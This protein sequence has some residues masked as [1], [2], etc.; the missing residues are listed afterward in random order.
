[1]QIGRPNY[2]FKGIPD[3][4]WL[5]GFSSGDGSFN[6]KISNSTTSVLG[7]RVQLRYGIG[8]NIRERA[9]IQSLMI[10]FGMSDTLKN[11]YFNEVSARFEVVKFSDITEKI[12]PFFEKYPIVPHRGW[13]APSPMGNG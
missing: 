6:I 8:L 7:K 9:F 5:A 2:I 3:P 12:V 4:N 13:G 1:M 10:Y 11:V